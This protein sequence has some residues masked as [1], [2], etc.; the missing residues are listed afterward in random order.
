MKIT[1]KTPKIPRKF[2]KALWIMI[3]SNKVFGAHKKIIWSI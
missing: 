3:N 1:P 2:S